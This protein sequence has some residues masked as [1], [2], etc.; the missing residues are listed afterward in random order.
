MYCENCNDVQTVEEK[1]DGYY[2]LCTVC[3]YTMNKPENPV[4]DILDW[5]KQLKELPG[6]TVEECPKPK[7]EK[8]TI[9][10]LPVEQSPQE[11]VKGKP[12][13]DSIMESMERIDSYLKEDSEDM[14]TKEILTQRE[15]FEVCLLPF[16]MLFYAFCVWPGLAWIAKI[17]G[18][19]GPGFL[20]VFGIV[21]LLFLAGRFWK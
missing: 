12:Y 4:K 9:K 19:P 11:K 6:G 16:K 21:A 7:Y 2:Y 15:S 20:N 18:I 17:V 8:P 14:K 5:Q 13:L 1:A 3:K 10:D